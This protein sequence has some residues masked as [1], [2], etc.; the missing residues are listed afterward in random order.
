MLRGKCQKKKALLSNNTS[1]ETTFVASQKP[2]SKTDAQFYC[3]IKHYDI[4]NTFWLDVMLPIVT[5]YPV[6]STTKMLK[7]TCLCTIGD[8]IPP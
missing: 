5:P 3:K 2:F 8:A 7:M 1:K 6:F 4:L